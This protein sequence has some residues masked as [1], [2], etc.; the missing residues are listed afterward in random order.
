MRVTFICGAL[1]SG[2]TLLCLMLD[3]HPDISNPGE[4]DFLFDH[5]R[6]GATPESRVVDLSALSA[7]RIF[8]ARGLRLGVEE[9][10]CACLRDLVQ[11]SAGRKPV[12]TLNVHRRF[13]LIPNFFPEAT[14]IHLLRDPRDIARSSVGMGWTGN[15]FYG[16]DHWVESERS[17]DRLI[18]KLSKDRWIDITYEDL[19]AAPEPTL[20]QVTKFLGVAFDSAMLDYPSD[21][22]YSAPN[23]R[24]VQQWRERMPI[25]EVRL[26]EGKLGPM[27]AAKG[28]APS[29]H[30]PAV[31]TWIE[32]VSLSTFN[33]IGRWRFAIR[34]FGAGL[35]LAEKCTRWL[36]L[37]R[38]HAAAARRIDAITERHLK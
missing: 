7:D 37:K 35:V 17:W 30:G 4:A 26:I 31:A 1:R 36:R 8:R 2:T 21:T 25:R 6:T 27:L 34:R 33:K 9:D 13:D 12:L 20:R 11:Q 23:P 22:T 38:L 10:A 3:H 24:H 16:V 29:G 18:S 32:T 15:A 14:Y 5:L 19:V 28:Y